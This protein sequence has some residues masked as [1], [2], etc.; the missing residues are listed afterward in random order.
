MIL[1]FRCFGRWKKK[2]WKSNGKLMLKPEMHVWWMFDLF[3]LIF[4][5]FRA[6]FEPKFHFERVLGWTLGLF[7]VYFAIME[8]HWRGGG[9]PD[10]GKSLSERGEPGGA[11]PFWGQKQGGGPPESSP[12]PSQRPPKSNKSC[13]KRRSSTNW[14][15]FC[16]WS[17]ICESLDAKMMILSDKFRR[18]NYQ[19]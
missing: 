11:P 1:S 12:K 16:V 3:G 2:L 17:W 5:G 4:K 6:H 10:A 13:E 15:T 7:W 9:E 19:L 14:W 18:S 8:G